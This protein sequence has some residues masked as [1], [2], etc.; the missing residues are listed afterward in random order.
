MRDLSKYEKDYTENYAFESHMVACRRRQ[1]LECLQSFPHRHVLEVS[2]A[3]D[4]LVQYA[5][6]WE[7]WDIVEP[8]AEFA[9]KAR[10]TA[11]RL[12]GITVHQA[13]IEAAAPKLHGRDFDFICVSG[14][15]HEVVNPREILD[16]VHPL[17]AADTVVHVNVPN[18]R[19]L[20]NRIGV[21]MGAIPDVFA[22][23]PLAQRLQRQ[24]VF[25]LESLSELVKQ[26]GF[27]IESSG[28]YFL[29]PFTHDQ[30]Q[31]MLDHGII[32]AR[33]LDALYEVNREFDGLG[34]EIYMN[35]RTQ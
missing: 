33:V 18:A 22:L 28:S 1:V 16:A 31:K 26:A 10:E 35:V 3:L 27:R 20:H 19:S 2:C 7:S 14:L 32:D 11:S 9:D 30:M 8:G 21:R 29:K 25:D 15:L 4:P 34:A 13:T 6:G 5:D 24:R 12:P 23:S 17:C